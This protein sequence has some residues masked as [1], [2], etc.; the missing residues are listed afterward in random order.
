[1]GKLTDSEV[2]LKVIEALGETINSFAVKLEYKSTAAVYHVVNGI[3]FLSEGMMIRIVN[4][5][6]Q[7]NYTFMKTRGE[8]GE[9]LLSNEEKI[10]QANLF[11]IP[12]KNNT[13]IDLAYW[14]LI[15]GKIDKLLQEQEK[16]NELLEQILNKKKQDGN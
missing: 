6:P 12:L 11:N 13:T 8:K 5:F 10:N 15:P 4:T 1:M 2:I 16:T 3:N 9:P 7:V 14:L